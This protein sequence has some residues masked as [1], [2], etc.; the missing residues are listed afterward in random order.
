MKDKIIFWI[1][2]SLIYF[3]LAK[4]LQ[5]KY[6][7]ELYAIFDIVDKPKKI[8]NQQFVKFHKVWYYHD[9][10]SKRK[11]EPDLEYLKYIEKKYKLNLW[12]IAYNDRIFY[13][14]NNFYK[15]SSNEVLLII[16]EECKLFES[17]IDEIKPDFLIIPRAPLRE[18]CVFLQICKCKGVKILFL[19][20]NRLGNKC[21]ISNGDE[22]LGYVNNESIRSDKTFEDLQRYREQHDLY[23]QL[24]IDSSKFLNSRSSMVKAFCK[25]FFS[26]SSNQKSHYT[27]YGRTKLRVLFFYLLDIL[28]TKYRKKFIEKF[29]S[30]RFTF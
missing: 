8:Q 9:Y 2:N 15:F 14:F 22:S 5:E 11:S 24:K 20:T 17:I 30:S 16:E 19:A 28:R 4:S 21:I 25:F 13:Q 26:K 10:I 7:C 27:Y 23:N 18:S 3:G 6:D 29:I 1:D 12:T